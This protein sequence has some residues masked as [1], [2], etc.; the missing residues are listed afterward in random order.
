MAMRWVT[1]NVRFDPRDY[2]DLQRLAAASG[3]S[4]AECVRLAVGAYLGR[5]ERLAEGREASPAFGGAE[6]PEDEVPATVRG[7]TLLLERRLPGFGEGARVWVRCVGEAEMA[8]RRR[9]RRVI[10]ELLTEFEALPPGRPGPVGEDD[11][12][13]YKP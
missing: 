1:T 7:K 13:I 2:A 3:N 9:H 6:Q 11:R 8:Q 4:L 5:P 10:A 12:E